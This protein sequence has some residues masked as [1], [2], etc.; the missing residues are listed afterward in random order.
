MGFL[1]IY[2]KENQFLIMLVAIVLGWWVYKPHMEAI[3]A[4]DT[5]AAEEGKRKAAKREELKKAKISDLKFWKM[6]GKLREG[7]ETPAQLKKREKKEL[8][9]LNKAKEVKDDFRSGIKS[10]AAITREKE[11]REN[12]H[13]GIPDADPPEPEPAVE[14]FLATKRFDKRFIGP[15]SKKLRKLKKRAKI[16]KEK[17]I[18][19]RG[20][21]NNKERFL[22]GESTEIMVPSDEFKIV[23]DDDAEPGYIL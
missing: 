17:A 13:F 22:G 20:G 5:W 23:N 21:N 11:Q 4:A 14:G 18:R 8:E 1:D 7:A 10:E 9:A 2:F 19:L 3:Q 16:I 6:M 12:K 15:V